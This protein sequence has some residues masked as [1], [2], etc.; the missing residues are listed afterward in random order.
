MQSDFVE[1]VNQADDGPE[2]E[3]LRRCVQRAAHTDNCSGRWK[4]QNGLGMSQLIVR[5][6]VHEKSEPTVPT[7]ENRQLTSVKT[8]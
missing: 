1:R 8:A 2:L 5:R 3:A 6:D 7:L 4:S